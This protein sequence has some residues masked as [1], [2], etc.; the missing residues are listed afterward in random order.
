MESKFLKI[1]K[2]KSELK[3]QNINKKKMSN[4]NNHLKDIKFFKYA[5]NI[6]K[7]LGKLTDTEMEPEKD[8]KKSTDSDKWFSGTRERNYKTGRRIKKGKGVYNMLMTE[9]QDH[10]TYK[11]NRKLRNEYRRYVIDNR[12]PLK[13]L[14]SR[15][16]IKLDFQH[17]Y[18]SVKFQIDYLHKFGVN[19]CHANDTLRKEICLNSWATRK[20]R[21]NNCYD[22]VYQLHYTVYCDCSGCNGTRVW[23]YYART[24]TPVQEISK[25]YCYN[26]DDEVRLEIEII[27]YLESEIIDKNVVKLILSMIP[28]TEIMSMWNQ[29]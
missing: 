9:N 8:T 13:L 21:C 26:C 18:L 29:Y 14:E 12:T 20:H 16:F 22:P 24:C 4:M 25:N 2:N 1:L 28:K 15:R 27:K 5:L 6:T 19:F 11:E 3:K 23:G 7:K 17:R 10:K